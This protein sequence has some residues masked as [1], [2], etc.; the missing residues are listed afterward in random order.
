MTT[1]KDDAATDAGENPL[2]DGDAEEAVEGVVEQ[3]DGA[4]NI[5]ERGRVVV[6]NRISDSFFS[7]AL[8]VAFV[9]RATTPKFKLSTRVASRR[10]CCQ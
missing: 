5:L 1:A 9:E 3:D 7:T 4:T 2:K 6:P 8:T 10:A